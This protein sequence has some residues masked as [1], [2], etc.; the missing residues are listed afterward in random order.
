MQHYIIHI[1]E[2]GGEEPLVLS[3]IV[4]TDDRVREVA[5]DWLSRSPDRISARIWRGEEALFEI[6]RDDASG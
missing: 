4:A 5:R 2:A 1:D 3:V 6:S